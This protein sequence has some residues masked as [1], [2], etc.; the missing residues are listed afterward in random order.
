LLSFALVLLPVALNPVVFRAGLQDRGLIGRGVA[1]RFGWNVQMGLFVGVV[2]FAVL[3]LL[4]AAVRPMISPSGSMHIPSLQWTLPLRHSSWMR[5]TPAVTFRRTSTS[6]SV[7]LPGGIRS[8]DMRW[9]HRPL[10]RAG[11]PPARLQ[12]RGARNLRGHGNVLAET[13]G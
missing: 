12:P 3:V 9:E 10:P 11:K 4:L 13:W 5:G 1:M 6:G 8:L 2:V 7:A